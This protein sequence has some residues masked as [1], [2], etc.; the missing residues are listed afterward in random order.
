MVAVTSSSNTHS[1]AELITAFHK[2][3]GSVPP[4][5]IGATTTLVGQDIYL[6]G[7]RLQSTRQ[8]SNQVYILSLKTKSWKTVQP[9]NA[10][11]TPR[12]FHSADPHQN[13]RI[14]FFGGMGAKRNQSG[15]E[16]LVALDDLVILNIQT[17][18]WEYPDFANQSLPS[19]RYAHLS[20]L[21][22]DKLII[23]DGQDV[24]NQ[25]LQDVHIFDIK[26]QSWS[27]SASS[28][29]Y[30][31]G[32]YRSA[33]VAVTPV[34]LTPPFAPAISSSLLSDAFEESQS[35][36]VKV[37][38]IRIHVYSNFSR[39]EDDRFLHTWKFN[40]SLECTDI[41][42]QSDSINVATTSPP[43]LRFPVA[44]MCGQQLIIAGLH[45]TP[46]SQQFQIWALDTTIFVWTKIEAGYALSRGAWLK[47]LLCQ[48]SNQ[49][50]VF[51]H[52][53]RSMQMDYKDRVN[54][55]EHLA[56]VDMEIFG[57]YKPPRSTYSG[58]G[59]GLGLKLLKDPAFA[60]LNIVSTDRQHIGV[61]AAVLAQRW[62]TVRPLL[63]TVLAPEVDNLL[64]LDHDR[65]ELYFPDTYIVLI[66]FLQFI[67][68]D[69]LVTAQQHQPHILARLLLLAEMFELTR[70]KALATHAL[71]QILNIQ[72]ATI[73][74]ES[75]SLSNAVSLQIRALR[76]M[77]NAK[78]MMRKQK[79]MEP[80]NG[81]QQQEKL[82]KTQPELSFPPLPSSAIVKPV[83]PSPQQQQQQSVNPS[84]YLQKY[85]LN[86]QQQQ[87]LPLNSL[88]SLSN[89]SSKLTKH[90]RS[91]ST[92]AH[93]ASNTAPS[94]KQTIKLPNFRLR[95]ASST[96]H[97]SDSEHSPVS[98]ATSSP[99]ITPST[100]SSTNPKSSGTRSVTS[101]WRQ[102][103]TPSVSTGN[104]VKKR[105]AKP[106]STSKMPAFNLI[107]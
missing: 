36:E 33:A 14:L 62:P 100:S 41:R 94:N 11:P 53:Q 78:K 13:K 103:M 58:Y 24:N 38:D 22:N 81:H 96:P 34:V 102:P 7:G 10:P 43:A 90:H 27:S 68:T 40:D 66:A 73:I 80:S 25:Y 56:C 5:L 1:I 23:F 79:L 104:T 87:S 57:I 9:Q 49:F 83:L 8:M 64:V 18:S 63:S 84:R 61:N 93:C 67:Y 39:P 15:A 59:Q 75:A 44:F 74:Y 46:S 101:F 89:K 55:F 77:I 82:P 54:C 29:Q 51:G 45:L 99:R 91:L 86:R 48:A 105:T 20:S 70:L 65:R 30:Q 47:G 98:S 2:T 32:A 19:P 52:P 6:F 50:I 76:V 69:H 28:R 4:P 37:A 72:T 60:D 107:K 42:D 95:Q 21:V 85:D 35:T 12:Y 17:M 26:K 92:E 71:H 3:S 106:E 97:T 16:K 88:S 31:Y